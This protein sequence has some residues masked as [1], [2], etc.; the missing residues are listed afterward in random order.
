MFPYHILL[1]RP[2]FVFMIVRPLTSSCALAALKFT[3]T[4]I[5]KGGSKKDEFMYLINSKL[6]LDY[7]EKMCDGDSIGVVWI[8]R[9]FFSA[10][11]AGVIGVKEWGCCVPG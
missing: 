4:P 3:P 2:I 8:T 10:T 6:P 11:P 1:S 5:H 9:S 7:E